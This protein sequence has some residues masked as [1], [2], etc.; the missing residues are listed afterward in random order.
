[1]QRTNTR[2]MR[3][4]TSRSIS[5]VETWLANSLATLLAGAAI[6]AGVIGLL[7]AFGYVNGANSIN[8]FNDGMIW[9]VMG[10]VLGLGA[11]VFRREHHVVESPEMMAPPPRDT[12]IDDRPVDRP[13]RR[14]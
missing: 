9:L 6:A 12:M 1:M 11:N 13:M 10:L 7:V 4:S 5:D 14:Q 8:H 2:P 3:T